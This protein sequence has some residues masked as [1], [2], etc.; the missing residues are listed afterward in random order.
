MRAFSR[1][2][3]RSRRPISRW[4][5]SL[6]GLLL[7]SLACAA[8]R[9]N[10]FTVTTL[11]D[12]G[13]GSLR[14]AITDANAN[15]GADSIVFASGL[16]G[17]IAL[18]SAL[19]NLTDDVT[20]NGP[21]AKLLTIARSSASGTPAFRIF[22]IDADTATP[23][24]VSI[25]GLTLS[26]GL[27][28]YTTG[29]EKY[30]G[31]AVLSNKA[32]VTFTD[33]ALSGNSIYLPFA[34]NYGTNPP[35]PLGFGGGVYNYQGAMTLTRCTVSNNVVTSYGGQ[36]NGGGLFN[37]AGTLTL[38][39][40]TLS[41]NQAVSQA[42]L[43]LI[44]WSYPM[45]MNGSA[46]AGGIWNGGALTLTNCTFAG[47]S[48]INHC[49]GYGWD[50]WFFIPYDTAGS[51]S[52]VYNAGTSGSTQVTLYQTILA[53]GSAAG[54]QNVVNAAGIV[55]TSLG[56]NLSNDATGPNDGATDR[57]NMDAKLSPLN[58][59]GGPTPTCV[60]LL[61]SPAID[62]GDLNFN[63]TP[64]ATDQRGQPRVVN[65]RV[66]IGA[67]ERQAGELVALNDA[68]SVKHDHTSRVAASGV[69]T[70]DTGVAP[71]S[72]VLVASAAHGTLLLNADGSF[73][74]TPNAGYALTSSS[75]DSFTYA[76][77][78]GIGRTS[79]VATVT[80]T[81][82]A[83]NAPVLTNSLSATTMPGQA[84]NF[85]ATATDADLPDDA[86]TFALVNAPSGMTI[87]AATGAIAWT[88]QAENTTTF[89]IKVTDRYGLSAQADVHA[90]RV[91]QPA[92]ADQQ[93]ERNSNGRASL[94]PHGNGN[95]RRPAQRRADVCPC[96][97]PGWHDH[98]RG[99]RRDRVDTPNRRRVYI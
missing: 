1:I 74:Y 53:S 40:C 46:Y 73:V 23:P 52:S 79:N 92:R 27:I 88:P 15:A 32:N 62:A 33:C 50:G 94:E 29:G 71:L 78:D 77:Q 91:R 35:V 31:G 41:G 11:N 43:I 21:G 39:N 47:N 86:L 58:Y 63:N 10:T 69:L 14:Q 70:N 85:T 83:D 30:Y 49:L 20:L 84:W 60:P 34:L 76:V 25:S 44:R 55:L 17:T 24:T 61:G 13:M 6:L 80:I 99:N 57:L 64:P 19:P 96:Q 98:Q 72:A 75:T 66:D 51:G 37:D 36:A 82:I 89:S 68:Y 54:G 97:R 87:N 28:Q 45:I 95:G 48:A 2:P 12:S 67:V 26:N 38:T 16:T 81:I 65:G 93:P 9:A 8:S 59:Y 5:V 22:T 4:L 90:H 56:Y 42:I 7:F 18:T 3:L